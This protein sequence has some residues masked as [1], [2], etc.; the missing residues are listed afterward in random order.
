[1]L[2]YEKTVS[3]YEH[4][5]ENPPKNKSK[6]SSTRMNINKT[7]QEQVQGVYPFFVL[8]DADLAA[9]EQRRV[10]PQ[11]LRATQALVLVEVLQL[12]RDGVKLSGGCWTPRT[13]RTPPF[14]VSLSLPSATLTTTN[15]Y[16]YYY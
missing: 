6:V 5:Y 13:P 12:P 14:S 1:M 9:F 16:S 11:G 8:Q 15:R 2:V 7:T 10:V 3:T 4:Q